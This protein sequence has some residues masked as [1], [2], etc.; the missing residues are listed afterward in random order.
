MDRSQQPDCKVVVNAEGQYAVWPLHKD[1]A[2][3]WHDA[4]ATGTHDECLAHV[5]RVWRDMRPA[6]L[7]EP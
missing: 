2:P 7:P 4:N 3:G 6:S 5:R 1:N